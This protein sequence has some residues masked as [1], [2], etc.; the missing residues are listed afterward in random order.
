MK[1]Q[2]QYTQKEWFKF[3]KKEMSAD[4]LGNDYQFVNFFTQKKESYETISMQEL[5]CL[6]Y[7]IVLTDYKTRKEKLFQV[8]D[9]VNIKNLNKGIDKF[10]KG[11]S[12]F[13]KVVASSQPK[14]KN[15]KLGISQRE[16]DKLFKSRKTKGNS[17]DF[18]NEDKKTRKKRNKRKPVQKEPDYSFL[19]GKK[20]KFF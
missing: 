14:G 2:K 12:Q 18:W 10:N 17:I 7:D 1:Y 19:T 15:Q 6:K 11:I 3:E 8:I 20:V 16:Y 9:K 4:A 13:S 5:L